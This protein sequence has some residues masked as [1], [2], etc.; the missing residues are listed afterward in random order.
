[1]TKE[2][3]DRIE[4]LLAST[5]HDIKRHFGDTYPHP[6]NVLRWL[7]NIDDIMTILKAQPND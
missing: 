2:D 4:A 3:L 6:G 7:E 5:Y 1:M